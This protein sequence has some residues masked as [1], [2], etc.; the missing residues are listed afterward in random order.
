MQ[1]NGRR[2]LRA[3]GIRLVFT[4]VLL[5][6]L[7]SIAEGGSAV[8]ASRQAIN[9]GIDAKPTADYVYGEE[10]LTLVWE[11]VSLEEEAQGVGLDEAKTSRAGDTKYIYYE[12]RDLECGKLR[13]PAEYIEALTPY[14]GGYQPLNNPV[15]FLKLGE[16][17]PAE[18]KFRIR[19]EAWRHAGQFKGYLTSTS[20]LAK[21]GAIEFNVDVKEF[22]SLVVD[23]GSGEG[24]VVVVN[25]D[26]GPGTYKGEQP[27]TVTATTNTAGSTLTVSCDGLRFMGG[28]SST[29]LKQESVPVIEP[30]AIWLEVSNGS[31]LGRE[32]N[33]GSTKFNLA[34]EKGD[35]IV[36]SCPNGTTTYV[37]EV[38]V[39]TELQ[40]VAGRY[41]G[42]IRF[43]LAN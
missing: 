20:P 36:F 26:Q 1:A 14:S 17:K 37:F 4:L 6:A 12:V 5:A 24:N 38:R 30:S 23:T 19:K 11:R 28:E 2:V 18:I 39:K 8:K 3:K 9:I 27:I 32:G 43:T 31:S 25:A 16:E 33:G 34:N 7:G 29:S 13:I 41:K 40:H 10:G 35:G 42:N 21:H 15:P 22:I